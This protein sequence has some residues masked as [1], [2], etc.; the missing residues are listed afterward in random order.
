VITKADIVYWLSGWE[1]VHKAIT[2]VE[3]AGVFRLRY[4][5]YVGELNRHMPGTD[6]EKKWL[7]DQEDEKAGTTIFYTGTPE[8]VTGTIRVRTWGPGNIPV[9]DFNAFSVD[10]FPGIEKL[11]A[12]E[13]GR[14]AI[15]PESRGKLMLP[16]LVRAAIAELMGPRNADLVFCTCSPGH[17]RVYRSLGMVPYGGKL[18]ETPWGPIQIPL[19]GVLSDIEGA[20]RAGSFLTPLAKK[21]FGPGKRP[22]LDMKPFAQIL[23]PDEVPV[24]SS[25]ARVLAGL[26]ASLDDVEDSALMGLPP[27]AVKKL[28]RSGFLLNFGSGELV[29]REG[30]REAEVFVVLDGSF[31]VLQDTRRVALLEKG[32]LIGEIAF[33]TQ[34]GLGQRTATVRSVSGGRLLVLRR[35]FLRELMR[36][37]PDAGYQL[38][39]NMG[40][41]MAER[42]TGAAAKAEG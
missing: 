5:A 31:E 19:V 41:I 39:M 3:R 27:K 14:L 9:K 40:R 17:V 36:S 6:H 42:L 24:E 35:K 1:P 28:A 23:N 21:H 33:F 20:R 32:A 34:G 37:D 29:I 18:I 16:A 10:R 30:S 25:P 8:N 7:T 26:R 11:V 22:P 2:P 38:L 13:L 12:S 15:V 4:R